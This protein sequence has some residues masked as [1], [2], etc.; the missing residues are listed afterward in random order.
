[1]TDDA[2][3]TAALKALDDQEAAVSATIEALEARREQIR[4]ARQ[5][6]LPLAS[7]EPVEFDGKLTDAVRAV[8]RNHDG[9]LVPIQV[10]DKVKEL[11]YDM[12]PHS[13]QMAAI[14]GVLKRLKEAKEVDTKEWKKEP[15]IIRYFWIGPKAES[16]PVGR[17]N[18]YHMSAANAAIQANNE[19]RRRALAAAIQT[20][21]QTGNPALHIETDKKK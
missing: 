2:R 16:F 9:S 20:S 6:L 5:A 10:R 3:L 7:D 12:T 1:M 17:D 15:G 14:H 11:G 13:N 21:M 19:F 4:T 8:L 18:S